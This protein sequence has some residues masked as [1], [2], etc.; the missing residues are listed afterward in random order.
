MTDIKVAIEALRADAKIWD[1]A[2]DD[3][4]DPTSA[5]GPLVL[6][7][8][9]DVTGMGARM[10][11]HTTYENAR[12]QTEDLL[13]QAADYFHELARTLLDVA[14]DY[15]MREQDREGTFK[16]QESELEGE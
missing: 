12:T 8:G 11:I 7:G 14:A 16:Q 4:A 5:V 10:G 9:N 15:E 13:G 6:N 3:L 2:A 1:Q